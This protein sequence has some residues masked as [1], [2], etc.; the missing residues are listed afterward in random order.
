ML[1]LACAGASTRHG[2]SVPLGRL[3]AGVR[4]LHYDLAL[5][6][7][8]ERGRFSGTARI[9]L[10]LDRPVQTI[11]LHGKRLEVS[12]VTIQLGAGEP[13]SARWEAADPSGLA[14]VRLPQQ[15]GPGEARLRIAWDAAFDERG[16][17]LYRVES[18]G[19]AYVFTHFEPLSA[20]AAFPAFDEPGFKTPF[21]IALSVRDG[22]LAVGNTPIAETAALPDGGR[23][24]RFATTPPLP[25]YLIAWAVGPLDVV[26]APA[27]PANEI[28]A[29]AIPFRGIAVRGRGSELAWALA[30]TPPIVERLEGYFE[31]PYPYAK[32]DVIAVPD[33]GAGAMENVGAVFFRE[34]YLLLDGPGVK[35]TQRR[36][37][38]Y[39]MAHELAHQWFGNLVTMPWWNDLWLNEAFATW[40]GRRIEADVFP[41]NDA[42]GAE[43][44]AIHW[45]MR[46]DGLVSARSIRQP[47][48]DQHDIYNAFDAITYNKGGGVL[49]MFERWL[50]PDVFRDGINR[51]LDEHRMGTATAS[52]LLDA[53]SRAAGR[54]VAA[55]F[56]TFLTRPG[57]PLLE[58]ESACDASG[59][60]IRL[61]QSRQLPLGSTGT[62]DVTWQIPVCVRFGAGDAIAERCDLLVEREARVD[63]GDSCP[64]WFMPNA[65]AAGYYRFALAADDWRDLQQHGWRH[66]NARERLSLASNLEVAFRAGASTPAAVYGNLDVLAADVDRRVARA[67]MPLLALARNRLVGEDLQRSVER[68][69][70]AL[71][72]PRL[73]RLGWQA[74][75]GESGE[76]ALLRKSLVG[77]LALEAREPAV[78][79]EAE[80][81]G[82][83][84]AGLDGAPPDATA[85][86]PE[87]VATALAVVVQEGDA[88]DFTALLARLRESEDG[89]ARRDI[90][91][92]LASTRDPELTARARALALDPA[93]RPSEVWTPL[94]RQSEEPA[95]REA[96]WRFVEDNFD[97]LV[98]HAGSDRSGWMPWL[99]AGFCDET[100]GD[101][102][103]AFLRPRIGA[104]EGGPR[105]LASSLEAIRLCAALVA[106]QGPATAQYFAERR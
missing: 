70:S 49:A 19:D 82:R 103:A 38:G 40:L 48:E 10:Q 79:Q 9:T 50:S 29:R 13:S 86:A 2:E 41:E 81:R 35:E 85:L 83:R 71:Y 90:L 18:G 8:P 59:G 17:G 30:R 78:R 74:K 75:P 46:S 21:D 62:R 73:R 11:W 98:A 47:I 72:A 52:D 15:I 56:R 106:R 94:Y 64:D 3:P 27:L 69:G 65:D 4:P 58:A 68:F 87:L 104:L 99:A 16:R 89:V 77:F 66:L 102:V 1:A 32:L 42:D 34:D 101:E 43:L 96:T 60:G 84:Y 5:A 63:L 23:R 80:R 97:A 33:F 28:R 37:F 91:R 25:T 20:R 26:E 57:V 45:A 92:A 76:G 88:A 54:D 36:A 24:I 12:D 67:P 61:R 31:S 39:I 105:N 14:A 95:T 7:D 22:D 51:Y 53:L 93:L 100:R 6:I 55:P 44:D